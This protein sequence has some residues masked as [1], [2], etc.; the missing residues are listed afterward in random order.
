ML[1]S[2]GVASVGRLQDARC[3][4]AGGAGSAAGA[5]ES[6]MILASGCVEGRV[7]KVK[8]RPCKA[9]Y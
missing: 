4:L 5:A 8:V 3:P 9:S 2:G 1:A 6:E 7:D